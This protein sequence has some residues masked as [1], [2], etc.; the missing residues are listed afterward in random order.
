MPFRRHIRYVPS[1][2]TVSY[3]NDTRSSR[4]TLYSLTTLGPYEQGRPITNTD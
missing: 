3:G 1:T 4:Y 2:F